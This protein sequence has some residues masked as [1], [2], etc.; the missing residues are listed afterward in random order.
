MKIINRY[1]ASEFLPKFFTA[2]L[3]FTSILLMDQ[4]FDLVDLLLNKGVGIFNTTKLFIYILPSL[5]MFTVPMSILAA[6]V[7]LFA[8]LNED[9]EIIAIR[10]AGITT[11]T[12]I[13]PI[14]II[15]FFLSLIM[16]Y[17]NSTLVPQANFRFKKLYYQILFKNPVMQFSEKNFV[18][19][20]NYDIYIKK[21]S[22]DNI[23]NNILI[24]KWEEGLPTITSA[25]TAEMVIAEGRGILFRLNNGKILQENIN[26]IGEF[27]VCNFH[28]NEMILE[29]DQNTNIFANRE[30]GMRELKSNEL[31]EKIKTSAPNVKNFFLTEYHLRI[32]LAC[33]GFIFIFVA[34]PISLFNKKRAKSFGI[35]T[36]IGIMFIYYLI[37]IAGTTLGQRGFMAPIIAL[38]IPN[39][40]VGIAGYFLMSKILRE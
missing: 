10:T 25:E 5:F 8:R 15:S 29:I 39:L 30:G 16:F 9:N 21:I 32:V 34:A 33:A 2:L 13:K 40:V 17:F 4:I 22:K 7:L 6:T 38:W 26:K 3:V 36:I 24:Y 27:S 1:L 12:I 37:L 20:Q 11:I 28:N 19:L 18:Q 23:L 35:T 14:I 31:L